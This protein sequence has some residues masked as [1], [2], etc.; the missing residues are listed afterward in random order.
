MSR[1]QNGVLLEFTLLTPL[2]VKEGMMGDR[3]RVA[4]RKEELPPEDSVLISFLLY[5]LIASQ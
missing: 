2:I 1:D 5:L 4:N 3:E